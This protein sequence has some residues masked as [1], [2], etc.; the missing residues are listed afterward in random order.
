M[1]WALVRFGVRGTR[2]D[3]NL[4]F[5]ARYLC[6]DPPSIYSFIS[7]SFANT[8]LAR[9]TIHFFCPSFIIEMI[10]TLAINN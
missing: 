6:I 4:M 1:G 2:A 10:L 3:T 5:Y 7:L 9:K 8:I